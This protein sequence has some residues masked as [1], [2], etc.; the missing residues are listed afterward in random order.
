MHILVRSPLH[1]V[2]A[3]ASTQKG[4]AANLHFMRLG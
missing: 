2:A 4:K 3:T 1:R